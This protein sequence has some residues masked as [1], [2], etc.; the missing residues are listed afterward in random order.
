MNDNLPLLAKPIEVVVFM[1]V[2]NSSF[3]FKGQKHVVNKPS[4]HKNGIVKLTKASFSYT[5][6]VAN[7]YVNHFKEKTNVTFN[8][9]N[10][11]DLRLTFDDHAQGLTKV[12]DRLNLTIEY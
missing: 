6:N 2:V 1:G 3:P 9:L 10:Q 5:H 8:Q 7:Q 12:F 4:Q 11:V